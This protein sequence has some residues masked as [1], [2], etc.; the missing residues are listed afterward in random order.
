MSI[1][2][3]KLSRATFSIVLALSVLL[4][5]YAFTLPEAKTAGYLSRMSLPKALLI[6]MI[7]FSGILTVQAWKGGK[8][9]HRNNKEASNIVLWPPAVIYIANIFY[10]Y[11]FDSLGFM[12]TSIACTIITLKCFQ[13]KSWQ[14]IS[15]CSIIIPLSMLIVFRYMLGLPIPTSPFS[16][17]F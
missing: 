4:L 16:Y 7:L 8:V 2:T 14:V 3:E 1:S 13:I 11:L 15:L 6:L 5:I 10:A 17:L 9:S 12:I